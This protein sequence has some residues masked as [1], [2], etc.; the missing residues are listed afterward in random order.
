MQQDSLYPNQQ[1][2]IAV[3]GEIF[4][5]NFVD[6]FTQFCNRLYVE[7]T[8][9]VAVTFLKENIYP[10]NVAKFIKDS[11][12]RNSYA[13]IMVLNHALPRSFDFLMQEVSFFVD[14]DAY[15]GLYLSNKTLS[16]LDIDSSF[17]SISDLSWLFSNLKNKLALDYKINY[18]DEAVDVIL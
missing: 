13:N 15:R 3:A 5:A 7:T 1:V 16:K 4:S 9:P 8:S 11:L 10:G 14:G 17:P 18:H 6:Y 2:F 12:N